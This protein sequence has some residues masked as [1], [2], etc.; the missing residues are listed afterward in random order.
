MIVIGEKINSSIPEVREIIMGRDEQLLVELAKKQAEAGA[1]FIDI[2]VGT[3]LGTPRDEVLA[4]N[5]AVGTIQ[6]ELKTPLSIDSPDPTVI[7]AGLLTRDG[8]PS[9]INSVKA[10]QECMEQVLPL[11]RKHD[12]SVVALAM[13]ESGI[14]IST[15]E[16]LRACDKIA[17]ACLKYEVPL[18]S[19]F[20]DPLVLPVSTDIRQGT[21]TL[22]TLMDIKKMF[23]ETKTVVGLSNVSYGL[24]QR[25]RLNRAFLHMAVF[26]GLDAAI[27]DPLDTELMNAVKTANVL[28]GKDR[29]CRKYTRAF[30]NRG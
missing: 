10:E 16:R 17:A 13:D 25:E 24:P 7:A 6:L 5:W 18:E 15:Q 21:V 27:M 1:D 28:V 19:V 3:G 26:A 14:P 29:H 12:A 4:M 11:A 22:S 30:R 9:L 8:R 20:F 2:N 23:P